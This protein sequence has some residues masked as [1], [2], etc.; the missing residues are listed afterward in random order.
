MKEKAR[1]YKYLPNNPKENHNNLT[2]TFALQGQGRWGIKTTK[3]SK[4]PPP[5]KKKKF[6]KTSTKENTRKMEM[7]KIACVM[8]FVAAS[9]SVVMAS[10]T[11]AAHSTPASHTEAPGHAE[12]PAS[13]PTPD[14][15]ATSGAVAAMPSLG[16]L[17]GASLLSLVAYYLH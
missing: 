5:L 14:G 11:N 17:V 2:K 9:M 13:A 1:P 10:A 8:I 7:K 12:A 16:S 6:I 4:F 15:A 3:I